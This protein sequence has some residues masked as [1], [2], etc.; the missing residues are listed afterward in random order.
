LA[1]TINSL[2]PLSFIYIKIT[3]ARSEVVICESFHISE[4]TYNHTDIDIFS[5]AKL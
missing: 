1:F 5:F 4:R 3:L 2:S